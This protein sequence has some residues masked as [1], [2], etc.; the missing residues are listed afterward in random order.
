MV[1]DLLT[2]SPN[3]TQHSAINESAIALLQAQARPGKAGVQ[4]PTQL[5]KNK[6]LLKIPTP[7][8]Q[9]I[10]STDLPKMHLLLNNNSE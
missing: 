2:P 9:P 3:P 5:G 1:V 6:S 4:I 8:C 10:S 7:D